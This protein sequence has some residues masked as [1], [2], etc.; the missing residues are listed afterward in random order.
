[1]TFDV[2]CWVHWTWK[3]LFWTSNDV[4]GSM[5]TQSN[6]NNSTVRL[7]AEATHW[8]DICERSVTLSR[9]QCAARREL[10]LNNDK[11][12]RLSD[13][14]RNKWKLFY[15]KYS[16]VHPR[17]GHEGPEGEQRYTSTLSLTSALY[18]GGWLTP[19]LGRFTSGKET[20]HPLYRRK[21]GLQGLY[22]APHR[23]STPG[24]SS[25]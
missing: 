15:T 21:A 3:W 14:P 24:P 2:Q 23:D 9:R 12:A 19:R 20:R 6:A 17:T 7:T 4:T 22:L 8:F 13:H 18:G 25:T 11:A 16:K 5:W 1:M 10:L